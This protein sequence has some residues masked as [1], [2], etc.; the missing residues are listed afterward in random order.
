VADGGRALPEPPSDRMVHGPVRTVLC[1][2]WTCLECG[3][4]FTAL[5]AAATHMIATR[6]KVDRNRVALPGSR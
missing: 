4:A 6:H 3:K 1:E 2:G 5:Q